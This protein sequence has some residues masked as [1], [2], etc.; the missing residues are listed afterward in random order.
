ME[1]ASRFAWTW[2]KSLFNSDNACPG[3][4]VTNRFS[5][6]RSGSTPFFVL[7]VGYL[8]FQQNLH[9]REFIGLGVG[10]VGTSILILAGTGWHLANVNYY[11][12]LVVLATVLYGLNFN[13][14][15]FYLKEIRPLTI[16]SISLFMMG[17]ISTVLLILDPTF[18]ETIENPDSHLSLIYLVILGVA[19]YRQPL[20]GPP[21]DAH[22]DRPG[23]PTSRYRDRVP[24]TG[25][26]RA[27]DYRR[28]ERHQ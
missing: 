15:K 17:S 9:R 8:F 5:Q 20:Q 18:S 7:A 4:S 16:T 23:V 6:V 2:I 13:L 28:R 27:I 19:E 21:R 10:F 1:A 25:H 11:A 26:T 3:R 22:G 14:I 24:A 12:F